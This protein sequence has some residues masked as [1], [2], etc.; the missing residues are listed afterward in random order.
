MLEIPGC[1]PGYKNY[2]RG[3][4][5][6]QLAPPA[7]ESEAPETVIIKLSSLSTYE[8]AAQFYSYIAYPDPDEATQREKYRIALA[9]WAV[10]ERARIDQNWGNNDQMI[11]PNIFSQGQT[12]FEN[13]RRIGGKRLWERCRCALMM[14]LP[15]LVEELLEGLTPT[16]GNIALTATRIQGNQ[17]QKTYEAKVWAP[18]KPVAHAA[19]AAVVSW[20]L[21]KDPGHDWDEG[22]QLC[23]QQPLI[24]TFF[25]E[26]VF[27]DFLLRVAELLRMQLPACSRFQIREEDTIQFIAG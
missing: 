4:R 12:L 17:N 15:H 7:H 13:T 5:R 18:V 11:R 20:T 25:Y 9:R 26:D 6:N 14:L 19:A 23:Y 3:V 24:A 8:A 16:V 1:Q 21:L 2:N 10:Q 27:R 22:H